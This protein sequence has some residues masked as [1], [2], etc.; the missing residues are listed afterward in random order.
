VRSLRADAACF[1][2]AIAEISD[3]F[4]SQAVVDKLLPLVIP[5]I[6]SWTDS[7]KLVGVDESNAA[8]AVASKGKKGT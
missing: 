5:V 6:S 3:R 4:G 8:A 7:G 1:C 2:E